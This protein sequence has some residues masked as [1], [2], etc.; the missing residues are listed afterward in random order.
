MSGL[1]RKQATVRARLYPAAA[2][3]SGAPERRPLMELVIALGLLAI[4]AAIISRLMGQ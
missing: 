3:T 4:L 1:P 2:P